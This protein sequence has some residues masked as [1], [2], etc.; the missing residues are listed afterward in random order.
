MNAPAD[1]NLF[2]WA[3]GVAY[4]AVIAMIGHLHM[5]INRQ[6]DRHDREAE[7]AAGVIRDG[8]KSLWDALNAQRAEM[9]RFHEFVTANMMTKQDAQMLLRA[10]QNGHGA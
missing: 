8:D 10:I 5:R 6:E 4:T 7:R 3:V 9:Q 2:Q 1:S